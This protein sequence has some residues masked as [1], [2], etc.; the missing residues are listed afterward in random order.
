V[1]GAE[2]GEPPA[3]D[4]QALTTAQCDGDACVGCHKR[5]PRPRTRV[6]R[7]PDGY[8]VLACDD[9]APPLLRSRSEPVPG[10]PAAMAAHN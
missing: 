1:S 5:W 8:P 9:C 10:R 4:P 6:G 3:F 7:L 2:T